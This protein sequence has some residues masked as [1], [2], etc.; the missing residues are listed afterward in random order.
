MKT[1]RFVLG[2]VCWVV[3][4]GCSGGSG[5]GSQPEAE[6]YVLVDPAAR[7]AGVTLEIG[8]RAATSALPVAVSGEERVTLHAGT[9]EETVPVGRDELVYV[10]GASAHVT[11]FAIGKDVAFDQLHVS[12]SE[13]SARELAGK[14]GAAMTPDGAGWRVRIPGVFAGASLAEVP[15]RLEG[16]SPVS[17]PPPIVSSPAP[18]VTPPVRVASVA[19]PARVASP[20]DFVAAT[21]CDGVGGQWRGRVYSTRHQAYYDFSLSV[22]QS[23]SGL[24]GTVVAETWSGS[25]GEIEPP[26]QCSG[27]DHATI[28]EQATGT[29]DAAGN[30]KFD[31]Y[32]WREG[33]HFCGRKTVDYSP[34]R[35]QVPLARGATSASAVVSDDK[36]WS[37]G[38]ALQLTRVSCR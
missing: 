27:S 6:G 37:D 33:T 25:T 32:T 38:L 14:L 12:G 31:S 24:T 34:D 28:L 20:V 30:M 8:E 21:G 4:I 17:V 19:A 29:L 15:E 18:A 7:Q 1:R 35:F 2:S 13:A 36:V 11:H 23:G 16:A 5:V 22:R 10:E 9:R 26:N 3:V